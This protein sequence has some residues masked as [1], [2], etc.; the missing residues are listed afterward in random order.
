MPIGIFLFAS[1]SD[2]QKSEK[3]GEKA[4]AIIKNAFRHREK[5]PHLFT[6]HSYL[7]LSKKPSRLDLVKSEE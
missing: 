6:I 2:F 1:K 4:E 3:N 7:L 5:L